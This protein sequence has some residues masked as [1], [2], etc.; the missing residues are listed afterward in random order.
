MTDYAPLINNK[1]ENDDLENIYESEDDTILDIKSDIDNHSSISDEDENYIKPVEINEKYI[2]RNNKIFYIIIALLFIIY[3]YY[4]KI[5]L[6]GGNLAFVQ[7]NLSILGKYILIS[8]ISFSII[9]WIV[10]FMNISKIKKTILYLVNIGSLVCYLLYD[11]GQLFQ[12]H[13]MYNFMVFVIVCVVI[14]SVAL[15]LYFWCKYAGGKKFAIQFTSIILFITIVESIAL[16]HYYDIW[17][18]GYLGKKIED[19]ENLCK[20]Q[21]P[22][23]WFDLLPRRSLNFF[24]GSNSCARE[25]HFDAKFDPSNGDKLVV[26]GCTADKVTFKI[27]PETRPMSFS[28]KRKINVPVNKKLESKVYLYKKPV[29]LRDIEAV[30]VTCGEQSK[31]VTRVTRRV[32]PAKEPQPEDKLNVLIVYIDALS[33][34]QF[35][36]NLPKTVKKLESLHKSGI[37]HLNQFFRYG[38]IGFNTKRNSLGLFAGLQLEKKHY[39]GVPIWEEYRNKGYVAGVADD[40]CEDWDRKYN[41]RVAVSLDHELLAP[42]CLPEYHSLKGNPWGMFN[43]PFAMRRRCITGHHV[44]NY[45]L[46]YTRDFINLYDGKNPWFF[47]SS[48]IEAHESSAEVLSMTDDDFANFF[49]SLKEETLNR[50]AIFVMSDHGL[51]MGFSYLSSEQGFVEHKL[52]VFTTLIPERFLNKYP[53]LRKNLDENEQKLISAYDIHSTFVDLLDFDINREPKEKTGEGIDIS[54]AKLNSKEIALRRRSLIEEWQDENDIFNSTTNSLLSELEDD[55]EEENL[56]KRAR[57]VRK[58]KKGTIIWGT[59]LLR[60]IRTNRTCEEI[61]IFPEDCV[62]H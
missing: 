51:H 41:R 61:L 7:N 6:A 31:L 3:I 28:E 24:M 55:E 14:N 43:G 42:F 53:E 12:N 1:K 50:T 15:I 38:V 26:T 21:R 33:R 29:D 10:S 47:R 59:S 30:Y 16:K 58:P 11:N 45:A 56:F 32:P 54:Q 18:N 25:E 8:C 9:L 17:V 60:N 44:H 4:Y 40:L 2:N 39:S 35:F 13:G 19:G 27:L 37:M 49:G 48:Y 36:R 52:P 62:C 46:N 5:S 23:P 20:V 34:R 22:L 57:K